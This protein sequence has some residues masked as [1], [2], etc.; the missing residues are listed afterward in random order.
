MDALAR[1]LVEHRE[2]Y[3]QAALAARIA[4]I[5]KEPHNP[6]GRRIPQIL[7]RFCFCP[8]AHDANEVQETPRR[9]GPWRQPATRQ[10][11]IGPGSFSIKEKTSSG[12]SSRIAGCSSSL[13]A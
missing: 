6:A 10:Y 2:L 1:F 5:S 4:L 9:A 12:D 7:W 8:T 11:L 13:A 3:H